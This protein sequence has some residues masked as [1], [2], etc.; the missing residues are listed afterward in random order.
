MRLSATIA[1]VLAF[2]VL[3]AAPASASM[4][5]MT[6]VASGKL[7]EIFWA[8]GVA[9]GDGQRCYGD[10]ASWPGPEGS[11]YS[12]SSEG[13]VCEEAST[14]SGEWREVLGINFGDAGRVE[15]FQTSAR[16]HRLELLLTDPT[17]KSREPEWRGVR[18]KAMTRAERT[19]A[20]LGPG[21]RFAALASARPFC[22]TAVRTFDQN[23]ELLRKRSVP[24]EY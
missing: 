13:K 17:D 23:R 19:K 11:G 5:Q 9:G 7:G 14:P 2:G 12:E 22:V 18:T 4:G 8:F 16:V 21:Y 20:K 15:L 6:T 24:C 10:A 1:A 3:V